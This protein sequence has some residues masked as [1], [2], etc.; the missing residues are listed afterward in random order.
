MFVTYAHIY[1]HMFTYTHTYTYT[2][3]NMHTQTYTFSYTRTCPVN[4]YRTDGTGRQEPFYYDKVTAGE[5]NCL[6]V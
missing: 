3:I 4:I 6:C 2:D 5:R 1:L